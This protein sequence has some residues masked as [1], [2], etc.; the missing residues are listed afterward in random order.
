MKLWVGLF[1]FRVF[2][3]KNFLKVLG[4]MSEILY[5]ALNLLYLH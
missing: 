5:F 1:F 3:F 2:I 4:V